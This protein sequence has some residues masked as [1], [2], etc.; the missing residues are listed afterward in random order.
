MRVFPK[1]IGQEHVSITRE[2]WLQTLYDGAENHKGPTTGE[3]RL[4]PGNHCPEHDSAA[5]THPMSF[6]VLGVRP[7]RRRDTS[8]RV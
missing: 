1:Y 7:S 6:A 5:S 8:H 3:R 2:R 4:C